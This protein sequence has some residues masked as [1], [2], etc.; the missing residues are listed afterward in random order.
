VG[1]TIYENVLNY[2]DLASNVDLCKTKTLQSISKSIGVDFSVLNGLENFPYEI[3][4]M[5]DVLSLNR[6]YILQTDFLAQRLIDDIA[7]KA[8]QDIDDLRKIEIRSRITGEITAYTP[9]YI[10]EQRYHDYLSGLY[11]DFMYE[12]VNLPY[13]TELSAPIWWIEEREL[14]ENEP[15]TD[16]EIESFK[17]KNC[18]EY[19]FN[20]VQIVDNIENCIDKL[21]NYS[22]NYRVCLEKEIERRSKTLRRNNSDSGVSMDEWREKY[23]EGYDSKLRTRYSY[24]RKRKVK[25]YIEMIQS[26]YNGLND[27]D[28]ITGRYDIDRTFF[29]IPEQ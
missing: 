15:Q 29:V 26:Q 27:I 6:K 24:D 18:I 11:Y 19:S 28:K 20:Q 10:T 8:Y 5:V 23:K 4:E 17:K 14:I 3:R 22:G 1:N 13:N 9:G 12:M 21:D 16:S 25:Q 2:I 7:S